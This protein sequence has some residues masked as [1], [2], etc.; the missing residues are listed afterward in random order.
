ML[1]QTFDKNGI[2]LL[3]SQHISS[4]A[5]IAIN[6]NYPDRQ[7]DDLPQPWI[8]TL[9]IFNRNMNTIYQLKKKNKKFDFL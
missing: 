4:E 2:K 6:Q 8:L 5:N 7:R 1:L 9:E 3:N